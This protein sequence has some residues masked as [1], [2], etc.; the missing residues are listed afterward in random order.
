MHH[1]HTYFDIYSFATS[2]LLASRGLYNVATG[3]GYFLLVAI[4]LMGSP[5]RSIGYHRRAL[6]FHVH[7]VQRDK[8]AL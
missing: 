6:E 8:G 5:K 3:S 4:D 2:G 7:G 1:Y